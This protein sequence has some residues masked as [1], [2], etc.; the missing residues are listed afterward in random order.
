M[1]GLL[2]VGVV[3]GRLLLSWRRLARA[4]FGLGSM[5]RP[6]LV[7]DPVGDVAVLSAGHGLT[8]GCGIGLAFWH[9]WWLGVIVMAIAWPLGEI[10]ARGLTSRSIEI[11]ARLRGRL[12]AR[13]STANTP[14]PTTSSTYMNIEDG[15]EDADEDEDDDEEE[16]EDDGFRHD[17]DFDQ[18]DEIPSDLRLI[19]ER[20]DYR[21][22]FGEPLC[23][24]CRSR[25]GR[26]GYCSP[27]CAT[28][29]ARYGVAPHVDAGRPWWASSLVQIAI[30]G[31]V[32]LAMALGAAVAKSCTRW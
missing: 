29:G 7:V 18:G 19:P 24:I 28:M 1:W 32:L 3:V 23:P 6:L 26:Q 25:M 20:R 8:W 13:S 27:A 5:N 22:W 9:S 17:P 16:D 30:G 12:E 11:A 14:R 4:G 2:A 15:D 31:S 21:G 10:L